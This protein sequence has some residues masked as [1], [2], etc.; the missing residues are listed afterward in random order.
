MVHVN[1]KILNNYDIFYTVKMF[2]KGAIQWCFFSKTMT[3]TI[4]ISSLTE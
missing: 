3:E 2:L 1:G 4:T